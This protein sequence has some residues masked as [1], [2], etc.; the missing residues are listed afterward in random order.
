MVYEITQAI[1]ARPYRLKNEAMTLRLESRF[2]FSDTTIGP[3]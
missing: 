2:D 1:I 3:E